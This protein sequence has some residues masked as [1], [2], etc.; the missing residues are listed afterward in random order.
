MRTRFVVGIL[1]GKAHALAKEA[2][3]Y[4]TENELVDEIVFANMIAANALLEQAI[5]FSV[6]RGES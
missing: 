3:D 2:A 5:S 6:Q 4:T 1:A